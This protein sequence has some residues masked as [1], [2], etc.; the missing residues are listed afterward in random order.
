MFD[1]REFFQWIMFLTHGPNATSAL[2]SNGILGGFTR[3]ACIKCTITFLGRVFWK[4]EF[5]SRHGIGSGGQ[6]A[7]YCKGVAGGQELWGKKKIA[8]MV[9][10]F[11]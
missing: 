8:I 3:V 11:S 9:E 4:E 7:E 10:K 6:C 5:T 2:F 1:A